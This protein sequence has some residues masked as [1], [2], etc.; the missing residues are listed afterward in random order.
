[1]IN[2]NASFTEILPNLIS[3]LQKV[4]SNI[5]LDNFDSK[6]NTKNLFNKIDEEKYFSDRIILSSDSQ[7]IF[8]LKILDE[9]L[10]KSDEHIFTQQDS[11][12]FILENH[13]TAIEF[14]SFGIEPDEI[15]DTLYPSLPE[16]HLQ[17]KGLTQI[18]LVFEV[19]K[20]GFSIMFYSYNKA[21]NKAKRINLNNIGISWSE[22][23]NMYIGGIKTNDEGYS[24]TGKVGLMGMSEL[25]KACKLTKL[26]IDDAAWVN[27]NFLQN[28]TGK[29]I[30]IDHFSL[31]RIMNGSKGY[32][33][34]NLPGN[35]TD[36]ELAEKAKKFLL[37]D[38]V[39]S[40]S[41]EEKK[42]LKDFVKCSK[43]ECLD[44]P[45]SNCTI[46]NSIVSKAIIEL[47]K[48]GF[49]N[50]DGVV[51]LFHYIAIFSSKGG[52]QNKK[53]RSKKRK[54]KKTTKNK[55]NKKTKKR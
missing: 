2:E 35:Y 7:K 54:T 24:I 8:N 52:K 46:L 42:V 5:T 31:V 29:P 33:E 38:F 26:F 48:N 32:Y 17:D 27:C 55:K 14:A 23:R 10:S 39:P 43:Q 9:K 12:E 30:E 25:C 1:M 19:T 21:T 50:K 51:I 6:A 36:P 15:Y 47:K 44:I 37:E 16:F 3:A 11:K 34:S 28:H 22:K 40:L 49:V 53:R 18:I 45:S 20:V 13:P 41:E 4:Y